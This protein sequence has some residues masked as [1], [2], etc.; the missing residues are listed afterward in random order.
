MSRHNSTA[1]RRK[2]RSSYFTTT[3]SISLVLFLLG[4]IGLLG[5]NAHRLSVYVK[6]NLGLT[7]MIEPEARAAEVRKIEKAISASALVKSVKLL[8]KEQAAEELKKELGEDFVEY[9]GYNPLLSSM[10]VKLYADYATPEGMAS[11][12]SIISQYPEVKQVYYQKDIV[13]LIHDNVRRISLVLLGFSALMLVVAVTLISNTVRL[14][15]YSKRFS[16]RTM[17]LVGATRQFIRRPFIGQSVMQGLVG[18]LLANALLTGVIY[19]SARELHGVIS[20]DNIYAVAALF[21]MV[22]VFGVLLTL[23]STTVAVNRYLN[24]RTADLYL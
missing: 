9:L 17:Q 20:F 24:L 6:E 12:E 13:N 21:G 8:S 10:E 16:I 3:I 22:F 1:A 4:I 2:I 5:L 7:V 23:T 15:V 19:L 18:G 14:M 11:V